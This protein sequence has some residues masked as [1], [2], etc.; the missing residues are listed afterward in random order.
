MTWGVF[1]GREIVQPTVVDPVSFRCWKVI[2]HAPGINNEDTNTLNTCWKRNI[3]I[4][5][6]TTENLFPKQMQFFR[7]LHGKFPDIFSITFILQNVNKINGKL[8]DFFFY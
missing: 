8:S 7:Y 5:L 6:G 1:P 2:F 4:E 3:K